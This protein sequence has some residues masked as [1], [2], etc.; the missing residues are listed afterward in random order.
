[1]KSAVLWDVWS[2]SISFVMYCGL[3][4]KLLAVGKRDSRSMLYGLWKSDS[5]ASSKFGTIRNWERTDTFKGMEDNQEENTSGLRCRSL[6]FT[7]SNC[8]PV[9]QT[10]MWNQ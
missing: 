4:L 5:R 10:G 7:L 2:C 1:M 3:T 8:I 6:C 9:D